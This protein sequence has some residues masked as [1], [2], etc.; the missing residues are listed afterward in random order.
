MA[1]LGFQARGITLVTLSAVGWST[2][3]LFTRL[4]TADNWAI[5][6]WRGVFSGL[7]IAMFLIWKERRDALQSF[8]SLGFAGW[9]VATI[10]TLASVAYIAALVSTS[11]ANVVVI[12]ATVPFVTAGLAWLLMRERPARV[13]LLSAAVA[14][15]G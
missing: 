14:L 4:V 3:G 7:M 12:Y 1:K 6:G 13:T 5:I 2:A 8:A 11:V 15:I 9:L 10:S